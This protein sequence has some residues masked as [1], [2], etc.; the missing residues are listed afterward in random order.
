MKEMFTKVKRKRSD[1]S[2]VFK[3]FSWK[4][5][6]SN[7]VEKLHSQQRHLCSQHM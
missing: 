3:K 4:I 6:D 5:F 1:K 2:S 7:Y